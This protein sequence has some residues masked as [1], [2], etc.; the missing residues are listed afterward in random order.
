MC[1]R[2]GL[3]TP[4]STLRQLNAFRVVRRQVTQSMFSIHRA[5]GWGGGFTRRAL[6]FRF[7]FTRVS[8]HKSSITLSLINA[9]PRQLGDVALGA[10][11][12]RVPMPSA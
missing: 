1:G 10:Y 12:P 2:F 11:R 4:G 8:E 7:A 3:V 9:W 6:R 5:N